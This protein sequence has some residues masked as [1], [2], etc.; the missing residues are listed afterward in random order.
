LP[1][2]HLIS[3]GLEAPAKRSMPFVPGTP[4]TA[5]RVFS[6][7]DGGPTVSGEQISARVALTID[8]VFTSLSLIGEAVSALTA[9]I[10]RDTDNGPETADDHYLYDIFT[11]EPNPDMSAS[12]FWAAMVVQRGLHGN[13]YAEVIRLADGSVDSIQPLNPFK[14]KAARNS[15]RQLVYETEDGAQQ[16]CVRAIPAANVLHFRRV[17]IDGI[18][19][20]GPVSGAGPRE[21][22]ALAKA[23][24]KFGGRQFGQGTRSSSLITVKPAPGEANLSPEEQQQ[25]IDNWQ[26]NYGGANAGKQPI[27]FAEGEVKVQD[28]G[29]YSAEDMQ[30]IPLRQYQRA[31]LASMFH[32]QP[33]QVGDTSKMSS[34]SYTQ[35]QLSY[36]SD[37]LGP[38]LNCIEQE[39]NRKLLRSKG[40]KKSNLRLQFDLSPRLRGDFASTMQAVALGRQWSVMTQNEGRQMLN[41]PRIDDGDTFLS[42]TNMYVLDEQGNTIAVPPAQQTI[43]IPAKRPEPNPN[44]DTLPEDK[45]P[46]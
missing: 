13:A 15:L 43:P 35:A 27:V 24:E 44:P 37:T 40:S 18:T 17:S 5:V 45:E 29:G 1:K 10:I 14:T 22:F 16:G 23:A 42:P 2:S 31:G 3:L 21:A 32:L 9:K 6:D 7:L 8:T 11:V 19:G 38:I 41:L 28:F 26:S 46:N 34:A 25:F 33:H 4:L 12:D 20:V 39:V 36:V 30:F